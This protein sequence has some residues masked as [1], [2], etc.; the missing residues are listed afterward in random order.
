[1][2]Q[3]K[4]IFLL[5]SI[6]NCCIVLFFIAT[7]LF[8]SC[9]SPVAKKQSDFKIAVIKID[10][11]AYADKR[12]YTDNDIKYLDSVFASLKNPTVEDALELFDRKRVTGRGKNAYDT[13]ILYTDSSINLLRNHLQD[14]KNFKPYLQYIFRKGEINT[15][16]QH[17]DE[18][19]RTYTTAK[20]IMSAHKEDVEIL[21]KYYHSMASILFQQ[22]KYLL[23]VDF[24]RKICAVAPYAIKNTYQAFGEVAGNLNNIGECYNKIGLTDS[25]LY[26]HN[27]ALKYIA[28]NENK[29]PQNQ[30]SDFEIE[31]ATVYG[32]I[33]EIMVQRNAIDS[34]EKLYLK[35]YACYQK[36]NDPSFNS[37]LMVSLAGIYLKTKQVKKAGE[38]LETLGRF[39]D[40]TAIRSTSCSYYKLLADYY[41]QTNQVGA[42]NNSLLHAYYI[43]DSLE[44]RDKFFIA[45]DIAKEFEN[46]EQKRFVEN[47]KKDNEIKKNYLLIAIISTVLIIV[48]IL[49][50]S[51]NL[52]RK[53]RFA[54][55]LSVLNA[56]VGSKNNELL[57]TFLSLEQSHQEN[58]HIMRVV[59]HDL[60]SPISAIRTVVYSLLKKETVPRRRETLDLIQHTCTDAITLIKDLLD[61]KRDLKDIS[62]ELVDMG[63]LVEQCTE[64]FQV[65]AEEKNQ[66]ITLRVDYPVMMVNRQ[67]IMRVVNN[68]V[69]NA[70]KFSPENA[71]I[72]I[73]LEKKEDTVLL[74]VQDNGIGIPASFKE[75]I[76]TIDPAV[77]RAGTKGEKSYGLGLSISRK[78]I[79][80]LQ[81]QLWFESVA[82]KGSVFYVQLPYSAS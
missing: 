73:Q 45:T 23:A 25:A 3:L 20:L 78:I 6:Y 42:A 54:E 76:F 79:E 10:S 39:I 13:A 32:D 67:N 70:I 31:K 30:P 11:T 46:Q 68:I 62:N 14:E 19:V 71:E 48:I 77:S 38:M 43:Q 61:N 4:K 34:A 21:Y 2:Q 22:H 7:L 47:L 28:E 33:A 16:Y 81:G 64:L 35:S 24:F 18:A 65:K 66:R 36:V 57:N 63:K 26:Y 40:T 41:L 75:K 51:K 60:K 82:G 44:K 53:S 49:L 50:A 52:N 17:Y 15:E 59:A 69:N 72:L 12:F 80:E 58:N 56:E 8:I 9:N 27:A 55:R 29:I 5:G 74:S 37:Y 1:M